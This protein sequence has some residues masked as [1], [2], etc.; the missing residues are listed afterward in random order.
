MSEVPDMVQ[1]KAFQLVDD[2]GNVRAELS[3]SYDG[4]CFGL[5]DAGGR[6]IVSAR[7]DEN[8]QPWLC[9][10]DFLESHVSVAIYDGHPSVELMDIAPGSEFTGIIR[11]GV[12]GAIRLGVDAESMM[13]LR[14]GGSGASLR[15][16]VD[17]TGKPVISIIDYDPNT[18]IERGPLVFHHKDKRTTLTSDGVKK[19]RPLY[20]P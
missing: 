16:D 7:L 14:F 18:R 2:E 3:M 1:A 4:P 11:E 13:H 5:F 10:G 12:N 9:I 20:E 19:N 15:I 17:P 6:Q 8:G